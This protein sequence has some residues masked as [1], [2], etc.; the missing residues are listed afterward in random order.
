MKKQ[1]VLVLTA[2]CFLIF[3][4]NANS[5][6]YKWKDEN[7]KMHFSNVRPPGWAVPDDSEKEQEVVISDEENREDSVDRNV[8]LDL[9]LSRNKRVLFNDGSDECCNILIW[10]SPPGDD[11]VYC[12]RGGA[13]SRFAIDDINLNGTIKDTSEISCFE[14]E[15]VRFREVMQGGEIP[16]IY[17]FGIKQRVFERQFYD[18]LEKGEEYTSPEIYRYSI[19]D[20]WKYS[21]EPPEAGEYEEMPHEIWRYT[22]RERTSTSLNSHVLVSEPGRDGY[23]R[24]WDSSSRVF[25]TWERLLLNPETLKYEKPSWKATRERLEDIENELRKISKSRYAYLDKLKDIELK[26]HHVSN[27]LE[28][29]IKSEEVNKKAYNKILDRSDEKRTLYKELEQ[30]KLEYDEALQNDEISKR[31]EELMNEAE[32]YATGRSDLLLPLGNVNEQK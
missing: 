2:V 18:D 23:S 19:D 17:F 30:I 1:Y 10:F 13:V 3:S 21:A 28:N 4:I 16:S 27:R 11:T 26:V 8:N 29:I 24:K 32:A 5:E 9:L 25:R 12:R 7:G 14:N 6:I 31:F 20:E 15:H 22:T